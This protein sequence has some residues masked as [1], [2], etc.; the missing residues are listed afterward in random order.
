[1]PNI[2]IVIGGRSFDVACQPGEE[3][4]LAAAA[5]MLDAEASVLSSQN[6]R[7][8][9]T[10]LLLMSGLMLADKTV[11]LEERLKGLEAKLAEASARIEAMETAPRPAPERVEV[12]VIPPS[13]GETLAEIAARAEAL[14]AQVEDRAAGS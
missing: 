11:G 8:P 7:L 2:E 5:R 14:A 9:E 1:M 3:P 12:P 10:R 4:Y 13:V 6:G